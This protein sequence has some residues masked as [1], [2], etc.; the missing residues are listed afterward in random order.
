MDEI[1]STVLDQIAEIESWAQVLRSRAEQ[2]DYNSQKAKNTVIEASQ[3]IYRHSKQIELMLRDYT[4]SPL[5]APQVGF[6]FSKKPKN[7]SDSPEMV[8][9]SNLGSMINS[10]L[11]EDAEHLDDPLDALDDLDRPNLSLNR[12]QSKAI[13]RMSDE[14]KKLVEENEE[15][16]R[17]AERAQWKALEQAQMIEFLNK[18]M[19]AMCRAKN[20]VG[21]IGE[22]KRVQVVVGGPRAGEGAQQGAGKSSNEQEMSE[23]E[24][25]SLETVNED[26]GDIEQSLE[27]NQTQ[28]A[29]PASKTVSLSP[30]NRLVAEK[31]NKMVEIGQKRTREPLHL[32]SQKTGKNDQQSANHGLVSRSRG[33]VDVEVSSNLKIYP[34][35]TGDNSC[36]LLCFSAP[37]SYLGTQFGHGITLVSKGKTIY[38]SKPDQSKQNPKN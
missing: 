9:T 12:T 15:L 33:I 17:E 30:L 32:K 31:L 1:K 28:N 14:Y 29:I 3:G 38:S 22:V 4:Q 26:F 10:G 23:N 34:L 24:G 18:Q 11:F 21:E 16:K 8:R 37:D 13:D 19:E 27:P 20:D 35:F 7:E 2:I 25:K 6:S 5:N 36:S